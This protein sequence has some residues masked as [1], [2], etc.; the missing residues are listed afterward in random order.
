VT[1]A[2]DSSTNQIQDLRLLDKVCDI[3][4][5]SV[6]TESSSSDALDLSKGLD[7]VVSYMHIL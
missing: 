5:S 2:W 4:S 1:N 6:D 3:H 7:S